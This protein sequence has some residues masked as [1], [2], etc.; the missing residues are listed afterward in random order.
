MSIYHTIPYYTIIYHMIPYYMVWR[1]PMF[2]WS[3]G[4]PLLA[5]GAQRRQAHGLIPGGNPK[6]PQKSLMKE[7]TLNHIRILIVC[8]YI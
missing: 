8:I 4:A 2:M 1:I 3:F 5:L 6:L 7:D